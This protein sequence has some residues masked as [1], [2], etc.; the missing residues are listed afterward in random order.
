MIQLDRRHIINGAQEKVSEI[1][2]L[3]TLG[4]GNLG[5]NSSQLTLSPQQL[6][7]LTHKDPWT[8]RIWLKIA[9]LSP[10][11]I[12]TKF[13]RFCWKV[14]RKLQKKYLIPTGENMLTA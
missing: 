8:R 14:T 13:P 4:K 11:T 10:K 12:Y 9:L 1:D 5:I 6:K 3:I 7:G 2:D